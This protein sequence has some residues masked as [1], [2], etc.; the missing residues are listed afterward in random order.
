MKKDFKNYKI[1]I[2][3]LKI[4]LLNHKEPKVALYIPEEQP[5]FPFLAKHFWK[6]SPPSRQDQNDVA[7]HCNVKLSSNANFTRHVTGMID[8]NKSGVV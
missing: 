3:L 8:I 7:C 1:Y 6:P 4:C 5:A 2:F